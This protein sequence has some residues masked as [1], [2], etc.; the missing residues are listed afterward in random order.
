MC[1]F[2][3]QNAKKEREREREE[4]FLSRGIVDQKNSGDPTERFRVYSGSKKKSLSTGLDLNLELECALNYF[5]AKKK[6]PP[7]A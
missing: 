6:N 5:R 4:E 2:A 3:S 1:V 7:P